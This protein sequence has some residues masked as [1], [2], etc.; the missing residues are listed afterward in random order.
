MPTKDYQM[1]TCRKFI[2]S[3]DT[4]NIAIG[5]GVQNKVSPYAD[6]IWNCN[7]GGNLYGLCSNWMLSTTDF[8]LGTEFLYD[9]PLMH[10]IGSSG[11]QWSI[12][13]SPYR[14]YSTLAPYCPQYHYLEKREEG[15]YEALSAYD[16]TKCKLCR[17]VCTLGEKGDMTATQIRDNSQCRV[18][19]EGAGGGVDELTDC[20]QNQ[21]DRRTCPGNTYEDT[22]D[23]CQDGCDLN[24][25][26]DR[27][28]ETCRPCELCEF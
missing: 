19:E 20:I 14:E 11:A 8:T 6:M 9:L 4:V 22:Q 5:C 23:K 16:G 25:Y 3:D 26:K 1:R 28:T 21:N 15:H 17:P 10:S 27:D 12:D 2:E 7:T 18:G 13:W 24:Y